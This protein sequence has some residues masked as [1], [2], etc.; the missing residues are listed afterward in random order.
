MRLIGS[1]SFSLDS[2]ASSCGQHSDSPGARCLRATVPDLMPATSRYPAWKFYPSRMAPPS[3]VAQFIAVVAG[4]RSLIDTATN[5]VL[6]AMM[7]VL[8]A[9]YT[10]FGQETA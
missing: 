6:A 4:A 2:A 7:P 3:W 8:D 10:A 9:L 5:Q 1:R